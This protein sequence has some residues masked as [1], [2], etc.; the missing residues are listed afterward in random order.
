VLRAGKIP[1]VAPTALS[2]EEPRSP[3][4]VNA[5]A[6]AAAIATEL[7]ADRL[8]FLTDVE[9][10]LLDGEVVDSMDVPTAE[11]LFFGGMLEGGIV[12]KL[13]AAIEVAR[14]GIPAFIGRTE[15]TAMEQPPGV[16]LKLI[17]DA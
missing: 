12:P 6:G 14:W 1:V 10:F 4:N 9:G 3:L 5:D 2:W 17:G 8:V 11:K 7:P 15:V 13:G 16:P